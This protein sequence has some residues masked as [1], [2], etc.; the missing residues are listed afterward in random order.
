MLDFPSRCGSW[1]ISTNKVHGANVVSSLLAIA[2]ST[3]ARYI[4]CELACLQWEEEYMIQFRSPERG[5][6]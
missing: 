3:P 6:L 4:T 1:I 2:N 5:Q